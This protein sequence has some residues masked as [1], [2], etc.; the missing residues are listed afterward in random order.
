MSR[1]DPNGF[2]DAAQL[3]F[4]TLLLHRFLS[5]ND[6]FGVSYG[7][8]HPLRWFVHCQTT[9]YNSFTIIINNYSEVIV[10]IPDRISSYIRSSNAIFLSEQCCFMFIICDYSNPDYFRRTINIVVTISTKTPSIYSILFVQRICEPTDHCPA[11][12]NERYG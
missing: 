11:T 7:V 10:L 5:E 9:K 3:P 2:L 6:F 1:P 8:E 4:V 12:A